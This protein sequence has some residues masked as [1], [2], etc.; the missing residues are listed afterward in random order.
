[1]GLL[2]GTAVGSVGLGVGQPGLHVGAIVG[3]AVG[4]RVGSGAVTL[5]WH[6]M[7]IRR[8]KAYPNIVFS[9]QSGL[10]TLVSN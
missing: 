2:V 10:L 7:A 6:I 4:L 5:C 9:V 1:M 8:A 3:L